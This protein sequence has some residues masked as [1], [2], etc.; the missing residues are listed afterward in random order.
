MISQ[1]LC[2]LRLGFATRYRRRAQASFL[3]RVVCE[4]GK[5]SLYTLTMGKLLV[6]NTNIVVEVSPYPNNAI[7]FLRRPSY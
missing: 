1:E 7:R 4:I 5:C 2:F 6:W 3:Q